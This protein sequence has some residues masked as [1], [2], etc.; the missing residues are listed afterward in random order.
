MNRHLSRVIIVQTM[1][2]FDFRE[3]IDIHSILERNIKNFEKESK[4]DASDDPYLSSTLGGILKNIENINDDLK[5]AAPEWPLEQISGI[6]KAILRLAIY[7]L[8]YQKEIPPKVVINEAVELG[9]NFGG[10]NSSKFINGVLGALYR[11]REK[12]EKNG[13]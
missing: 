10:E 12:K 2:E 3:K 8:L 1:Y 4:E 9:K 7:E 13:K 6:D 5:R 11:E